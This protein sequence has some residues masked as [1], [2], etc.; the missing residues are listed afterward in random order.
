[1]AHSVD[2]LRDKISKWKEATEKKGMK[3]NVGKAKVMFGGER[4]VIEEFLTRPEWPCAM[5]GKGVGSNSVKRTKC[6]LWVHGKCSGVQKSLTTVKDTFVCKKCSS[7]TRLSKDE[8]VD[9]DD[10]GLGR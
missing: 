8:I 10:Q 4:R 7:G 9:K 1:M 3:V 6:Q 5:C 2:E